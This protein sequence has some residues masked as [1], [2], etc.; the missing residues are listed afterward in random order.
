MSSPQSEGAPSEPEAVPAQTAAAPASAPIPAPAPP[1][2]PLS[3][4]ERAQ[5]LLRAADLS[6][7]EHLYGVIDAARH[8][9]LAKEA[10]RLFDQSA[11]TLFEGPLARELQSYGPLLVPID[12]ESEYLESWARRWGDNA[13][14]LLVA[15]RDRV[16]VRAHLRE[17]FV[18]QDETGQEHFFRFYDPRV[19]RAYLPTCTAEETRT[20]F[21]PI[22]RM[23]VES[24]DA[25]QILR[26]RP[27]AKGVLTDR[28]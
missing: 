6:K 14:I 27:G 13:G 19:L 17:I 23:I 15:R 25:T 2:A 11:A 22:T 7:G 20:F 18:V 21:G 8:L 26:Y 24:A 12:P 3:D 16:S 10:V 5:A 1:A 9:R 28:F 4:A